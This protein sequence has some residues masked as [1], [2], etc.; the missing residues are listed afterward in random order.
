MALQTYKPVAFPKIPKLWC[1]TCLSKISKCL[2]RHS[3]TFKSDN[4]IYYSTE[5]KFKCFGSIQCKQVL[6]HFDSG[7]IKMLRSHW[8]PFGQLSY[9]GVWIYR[10]RVKIFYML[11]LARSG[12]GEA[13]HLIIPWRLVAIQEYDY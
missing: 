5:A 9:S 8:C 11:L 3:K 1:L 6:G 12:V 7:N 4:L 13:Y 10:W 2:E